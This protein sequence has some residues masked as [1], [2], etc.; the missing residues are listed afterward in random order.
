[1]NENLIEISEMTQVYGVE[2]AVYALRGVDLKVSAVSLWRS[3]DPRARASP[4]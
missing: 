3:W 1:M 2:D 4:P